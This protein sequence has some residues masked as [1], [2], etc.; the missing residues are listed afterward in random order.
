M[1][2]TNSRALL[3]TTTALLFT[4]STATVATAQA[5]DLGTLVLGESKREVQTD[6]A[7]AITKVDQEEIDDRQAST[8][9][10]IIDSV[11]GV[12]LVNG[13]TP[14]GSGINIRGFGANSTY[15]TDQ[16]VK[17]IVD[18]ADVGAEEIYRVGTQLFTDP[19]LYR[20]VEVLRGTIGS[21]EYGSGVVGGVVKLE[22]KDASDFTGGEPG[23]K[24]RQT[25]EATSN[26]DG[27]TSSTIF[28]WQPNEN[29]ELLGNYVLRDQNGQIDGDGNAI[30]NSAFKL[31]SYL[32]KGKYTFGS[33]RDQSL[34]FAL[35][36]T[37]TDEKDVPYDTFSTTGG[38]FGNVDRQ[39]N[40]STAALTYS[41]NPADND[42]VDLDVVLSYADQ[43]INQE[44]VEGS[45][46]CDDPSNP[47]GFPFTPGGFGVVNADLRYETTKLT[48]KN[49]SLF[50]TGIAQHELRAGFELIRKD[51][52]DADSAPGGRDNRVAFFAID[53]IGIGDALTL[54]PALRYEKSTVKGSTAPNDGEFSTS[55]WM[56]GLSARY[57]FQNGFAVF[58][59]GAYT[60]NLPII[61][62]L[63]NPIFREQSE[64]SR[65]W[66]IGAS[67]EGEDVFATGATLS[68]KAT[69]YQTRIWD[70][71][72][73]QASGL[74][75]GTP[76]NSI[77]LEGLELEAS[78]AMEN[79][80]Y[81]DLNG[82][83]ARGTENQPG[84]TTAAWRGIPADGIQFTLGKKFGEELDLSW[85]V[86]AD[87]RYQDGT[88]I[89]PGFEVHNLRATYKPQAGLLEGA[90]IRLG[91]ENVFD[92]SYTRRLSTRPAPGRNIKLTLAKTL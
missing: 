7:T 63:G 20:S 86:I 74:P 43:E 32:L 12:N 49:T 78:Y 54:T 42:L 6:T 22:T 89:N 61:D 17:V 76:I 2:F 33:A 59:S 60:E 87:K 34:T 51:R 70:V 53:E 50:T 72:S 18:G 83:F 10:E 44:Y 73:S 24:I 52:L 90:E 39:V 1:G 21:F 48:V 92:K 23:L 8:V 66:E 68:V 57:D 14:Q 46:T 62:D 64:K 27:L 88:D 69:I 81:V 38:S 36:K 45:S 25:L 29:F 26:G 15:G 4:L 31:P 16:K 35:T 30:D 56:G 58:A 82:T 11:P 91:I 47:C 28:A 9:A 77:D 55:A 37:S 19:A 5:V 41:Y 84:G 85:E 71:T 75:F 79:G 65:T 67:Y 80:L 40:S 13:S 3:R